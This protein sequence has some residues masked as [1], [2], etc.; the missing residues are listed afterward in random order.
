MTT[1]NGRFYLMTASNY[2]NSSLVII[3]QILEFQIFL[4]MYSFLKLYN[5]YFSEWLRYTEQQ[6]VS[7]DES[8]LRVNWHDSFPIAVEVLKSADTP[9]I[10]FIQ[11]GFEAHKLH[12]V[13]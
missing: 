5:L 3:L 1:A 13:T 7:S 12:R 6:L 10:K 2:N 4:L 9:I 11:Y 8:H